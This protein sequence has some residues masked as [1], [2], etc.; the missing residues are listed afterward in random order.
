MKGKKK[1]SKKLKMIKKLN[2]KCGILLLKMLCCFYDVMT[3]TL[4]WLYLDK[5]CL[6]GEPSGRKRWQDKESNK[7]KVK[8]NSKN[9]HK[10]ETIIK[11]QREA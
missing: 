3:T 10:K 1:Q 8:V 7:K 4:C 11:E 5:N 6:E 2:G 9:I